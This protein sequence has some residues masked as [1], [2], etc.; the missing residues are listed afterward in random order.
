MR[1]YKSFRSTRLSPVQST[2][3]TVALIFAVAAIACGDLN[4]ALEELVA[5][6]PLVMR[7][8]AALS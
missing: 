6:D 1:L 5:F 2:R 8:W 4:A 3:F 7:C